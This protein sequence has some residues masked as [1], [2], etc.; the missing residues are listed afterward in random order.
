VPFRC[1]EIS[2]V[3][4]S[5]HPRQPR[6]NGETLPLKVRYI[7]LP[8]ILFGLIYMTTAVRAEQQTTNLG[9]QRLQREGIEIEELLGWSNIQP[10]MAAIRA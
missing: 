4:I 10:L 6:G 7:P 9:V 5:S 8:P 2:A 1:C 3:Q